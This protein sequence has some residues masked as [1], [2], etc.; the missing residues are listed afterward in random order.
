MPRR[1]AYLVLSALILLLPLLIVSAILALRFNKTLLDHAPF[2]NDELYHWHQSR[3]FAETGFNNGYYSLDENIPIAG[4]SH[5]YAWGAWVYVYYGSIGR[6][7]GFSLNSLALI[8]LLSFMAAGAY[9]IWH[10]KPSW[11]GL[12]CF[13]LV[14]ATF[15]PL[16]QYIP[17]S[18]LEVLNMAIALVLA[19]GFY[20]LLNQQNRG[21]PHGLAAFT[22]LAGLVRPTFA[23]YLFPI[24]V[25]AEAKRDWKSILFAGLKAAPLILIAA[26]AFYLTAA[27]FPHFRSLLFLGDE[28]LTVKLANFAAYIRQS[29]IWMLSGEDL[30]MLLRY[31]ITL[32]VIL[33]LVWAWRKAE[34]WEIALHLYNLVAFYLATIFFHETLGGHDYRVMAVHLLFSLVLLAVMRGK[35]L[36]LVMV[37]LSL[38]GMPRLWEQYSQKDPNFGGY[39]QAQFEAYPFAEQLQYNPNAPSPWCNTL[40]TSAFYVSDPAGQPGMLLAVDAGFGLSWVTNWSFPDFDIAIPARYQIPSQF[41]SRYLLLTHDDYEAWGNRLNLRRLADAPSGALYINRDVICR[42]DE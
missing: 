23:L 17:S 22:L 3:S 26:A 11:T 13:G 27:P 7:F 21:F 2:Y 34:R 36:V 30:V 19:A 25:L 37:A 10:T 12:L 41:Q 31:Q 38:L 39:V 29:L 40:T 4:F 5:Y 32:L 1:L 15:I 6:L 9:F 20:R 24:F 33:L 42:R 35:W 14:L 8:N 18:L 28:P 16:L